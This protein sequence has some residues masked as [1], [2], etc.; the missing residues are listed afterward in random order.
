MQQL[1]HD[2]VLLFAVIDPIGTLLLFLSITGGFAPRDRNRIAL[3]ATIYSGAILLLFVVVGQ[4]I[5]T[6]M[7]IQLGSFQIAGGVIL[8]L[9]SLKMLFGDDV[10]HSHDRAEP[11]HDIA[12]FPLAIPSM[13][14]PG[15]L[16]AVVVITD[17]RR[18]GLDEQLL[19]SVTLIVVLLITYLLL[20]MANSIHKWLGDSGSAIL[21]RVMGMLL[22]ALAVE[23]VFQGITGLGTSP[24]THL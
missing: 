13:A 7:G 6:A 12:V 23:I 19:T 2:F 9:F 24:P 11:G 21:I 3:R 15:A 22:C 4:L 18:Y 17:N 16:T 1:I 20:L 14:S 10:S 8:F 5:L